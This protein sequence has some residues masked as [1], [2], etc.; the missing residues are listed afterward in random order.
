[1]SFLGSLFGGDQADAARNA[2]QSTT[3][4]QDNAANMLRNSGIEYG[5]NVSNI[6]APYL[7]TGYNTNSALNNLLA[8]PSSVSSLP[9]YQFA[10]DQGLK[11]LDRSAAAHTGAAPA[12]LG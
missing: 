4:R 1:M 9:G 3:L 12:G 2:A 8:N 6:Y 5:Q 10:M 7:Q 11:A